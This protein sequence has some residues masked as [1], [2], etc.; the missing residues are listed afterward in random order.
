[1]RH[2]KTENTMALLGGAL[3]GAAA[4]YLL[5][6]EAG[7]RR[8]EHLAEA[9]GD[10]VGRAGEAIGPAW[11][12]I[13]EGARDIGSRLGESAASLGSAASDRFSDFRSAASDRAS[14]A[15]DSGSDM[16]SGWGEALGSLGRRFTR[17]ARGYGEDAAGS[18]RDYRDS[19]LD[20]AR[21]YARRAASGARGLLPWHEEESHAGAYTAAGVTAAALGAGAIYFLDG[22]NGRRRRKMAVDQ[23]TRIVN[24]CGR[25][26]RRTG[27]YFQDVMNRS[28]GL[29]YETRSRFAGGAQ[30]VSPETL[31]Q[32][33]RSQM[34]HV[35]SNA[36]AVSVMVNGGGDVTLSGRVLGSEL[37]TLLTTIQRIPGV[38]QI[39]NRLDVQDTAEAVTGG[40]AGSTAGQRL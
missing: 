25:A 22:T 2:R 40:D 11:E 29:A 27:Q 18:A 15:R 20:S 34:G 10:A 1:M 28:R 39:I 14:D 13:S 17:R 31:M 26:F 3:L 6:P 36:G 24:D 38:G 19:A 16:L 9:T 7:R 8:R 33:I 23:A 5:D 30:D 4:M 21:D 37:D 35:V 12:R 32:R